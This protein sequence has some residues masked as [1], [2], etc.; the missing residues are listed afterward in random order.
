MSPPQALQL[1]ARLDTN[2]K[3][4]K[5][6]KKNRSRIY[7]LGVVP[8]RGKKVNVEGKGIKKCD[9]ARCQI[10][11]FVVET[12][13][14]EH[15]GHTYW[16]NYSFDC[17]SIGVIYLLKCARCF[18][19]YV[20]STITTFRKRFNNHKSSLRKYGQGIRHMAGE[21]LYAHY[22][23]EEHEGLADLRVI[24]ID[25]TNMNDPTQREAFW[26][27]NLDTFAPIRD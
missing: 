5:K 3:K 20:G 25:K 24:I 27:Y 19:V 2:G 22:F 9:K 8:T 1:R 13:K 12:Q 4:K 14:F 18:K 23:G 17:D 26:A 6:K 10:C 16:I 7:D 11:N 21:H 15:N